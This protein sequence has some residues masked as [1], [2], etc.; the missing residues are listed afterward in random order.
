M[1]EKGRITEAGLPDGTQVSYEYDEDGNLVQYTN[2]AG[3]SRR[4]E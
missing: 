3:D 2:Q 1:D 4:Y